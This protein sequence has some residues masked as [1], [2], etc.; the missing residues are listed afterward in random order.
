MKAKRLAWG[1]FAAVFLLAGVLAGCSGGRSSGGE[2]PAASSA[3][4]GASQTGGGSGAG[5][6]QA[7]GGAEEHAAAVQFPIV[8]EHAFGQT[9]IEK[10]PERVVTIAWANHDVAL[11]LGVVPVGF[12]EANYGV[13]D[14]S[15]LLPWTKRKLEELGVTRPNVF[16]DTDGLD[17]EAI[18]D[19][20]PDVILAAYSGIT[21]EEYELLTRIAPTVAYPK[22]PWVITWREQIR[23][24][25][26]GL[27]IPDK[28]EQLIQD[29]EQLLADKAA[30]NPQIKG[31]KAIFAY[32]SPADLSNYW[33]YLPQDPR[34]GFL[35]E[36]GMVFPDS[37]ATYVKPEDGF[38]VQLSAENADALSGADVI[39]T[40]GDKALLQ[41]LQADPV[42]GRIPAVKNG[43]LVLVEDNTPLAAA[44][45]PNPLS[46]PYMLDEY[47]AMI[48]EA[49][50]KSGS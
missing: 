1:T 30:E 36:L 49:L 45:N 6:G 50:E 27:G 15:G 48:V 43:A 8:I 32:L 9:V 42:F 41:A 18:S 5:S 2:T 28:G 4:G 14:E 10:K 17:F 13:Q 26:A 20:D 34:A 39:V 12:S 29:L 7:A 33:I 47:V 35:E 31:K 38:A 37:A 25:A 22:D 44:L 23:M 19:A 40:Y 11:A 21:K 3:A 24:N 46:I 16:R